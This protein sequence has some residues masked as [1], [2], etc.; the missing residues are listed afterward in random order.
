MQVEI[1]DKNGVVRLRAQGEFYSRADIHRGF[2]EW[3]SLTGDEGAMDVSNMTAEEYAD[4]CVDSLIKV[5][6]G[7]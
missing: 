6:E 7:K 2:L 3:Y 1:K 5:M 4:I